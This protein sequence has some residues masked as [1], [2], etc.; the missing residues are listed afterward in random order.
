MILLRVVAGKRR[1]AFMSQY[2]EVAKK[3]LPPAKRWQIAGDLC[4]LK[5]IERRTRVSAGRVKLEERRMGKNGREI[6][7]FWDCI[8]I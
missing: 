1:G 4:A 3:E 7:T 6:R 2:F 5:G 8:D